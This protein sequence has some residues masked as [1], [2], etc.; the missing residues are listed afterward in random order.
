MEMTLGLYQASQPPS[1]K[2]VQ[3]FKT[4]QE[5]RRAYHNGEIKINDP[6]EI[7]G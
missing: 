2:P 4:V 6:I 3:Q 1:K 7:R 5:A